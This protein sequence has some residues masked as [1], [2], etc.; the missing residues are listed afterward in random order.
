MNEFIEGRNPVLEALKANRPI[1][2]ILLAKGI[3]HHPTV[4][5]II[6]LTKEKRISLHWDE[7]KAL[8]KISRTG[9]H[10]GV[11]AFAAA[12]AYVEVETLLRLAKDRNEP[13]FIILLDGI[14][15][16]QNL[17]AILRTADAVGAH[18]IVILKRRAVG[19]TAGVARASAGA[20]EYVGV[21]QV[22]NLSTAIEDL[23]QAGLW[24]IGVEAEGE[25]S[26][27]ETDLSGPIA[28][29]IGGEGKGIS[30]LVKENCDLLA[31]I[32]M[33]GKI[34]SLNTSVAAGLVLYEAF[35]QR[36][37]LLFSPQRKVQQG[38]A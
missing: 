28:V 29:V 4:S 38:K 37:P 18:G 19:L 9:R 8:D 31:N 14:E 34:S 13:P 1:N 25:K 10:Q 12:H 26:Y 17:G 20:V 24:I 11:I 32:P 35:R 6:K 23:K 21:A 33:R 2:N 22:P 15:D 30:R 3:G 5:E 7:K 16:P 36:S 27:A